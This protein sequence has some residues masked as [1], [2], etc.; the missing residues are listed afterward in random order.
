MVKVVVLIVALAAACDLYTCDDPDIVVDAGTCAY[1]YP[2]EFTWYLSACDPGYV[3]NPT[4]VASNFT[5]QR[6]SPAV[7]GP[8]YPGE[9]CNYDSDCN[10]YTNL[11]FGCVKETCTGQ[12]QGGLCTDT[13]E[14]EPGFSCIS[15]SCTQLAAAKGGCTQD[16]DCIPS[17]GCNI[18]PYAVIGTCVP[19][20]SLAANSTVAACPGPLPPI[21][22][23]PSDT[24]LPTGT[25][26]NYLCESGSCVTSEDTKISSCV[27]PLVS[28]SPLPMNC[29]GNAGACL[30]GN[31]PGVAGKCA[32]CGYNP[33]G[34]SYCPL[35][36]GDGVFQEFIT[37][38]IS[39]FSSKY[40]QT[41]N[42]IRRLDC[43]ATEWSTSSYQKW[44]YY[45][46]ATWYYP[47]LAE[48]QKCV[49]EVWMP[50]FYPLYEKYDKGV[51]KA[52]AAA[53]ILLVAF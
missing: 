31:A 50:E 25:N 16:E 1:F 17:C 19:Y 44:L 45:A 51:S 12:H 30:A 5:C 7:P 52:L 11:G 39:W 15:K 43:M 36:T 37:Q 38:T 26:V 46:L 2:P 34:T 8:A 13:G 14:C 29:T 27:N 10:Y 21:T 47:I 6:E 18:V 40:P 41:C 24:S 23:L 33:E 3:C 20:F 42:T 4:D 49:I 48:A 22:M 53:L 35:F 32:G 28:A 9:T